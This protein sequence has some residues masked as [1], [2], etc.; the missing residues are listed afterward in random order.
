MDA[1]AILHTP[2][3]VLDLVVMPALAGAERAFA[4][5]LARITL[6]DLVRRVQI[7]ATVDS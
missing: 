3:H 2:S 4:A 6:D 7:G 5:A 1:N